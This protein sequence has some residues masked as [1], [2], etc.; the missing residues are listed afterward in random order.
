M[1]K[2]YVSF[3]MQVDVCLMEVG[4]EVKVRNCP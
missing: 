3:A 2:L 4:A 1:K